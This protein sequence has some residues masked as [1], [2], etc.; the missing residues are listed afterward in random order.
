[1]CKCRKLCGKLPWSYE[2]L[3]YLYFSWRHPRF[4]LAE[5][6]CRVLLRLLHL[7]LCNSDSFRAAFQNWSHCSASEGAIAGWIWQVSAC[8]KV[9]IR[10]HISSY[11]MNPNGPSLKVWTFSTYLFSPGQITVTQLASFLSLRYTV[12]PLSH[13]G[14]CRPTL[15]RGA[16]MWGFFLYFD[17]VLL[18]TQTLKR[19][20]I[21]N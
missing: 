19:N 15:S 14:A 5:G 18:S 10:L 6:E 16:V 17:A 21:S 3:S 2:C 8:V 1:M 7:T 12:F 9:A 4:T 13:S 11:I 20:P